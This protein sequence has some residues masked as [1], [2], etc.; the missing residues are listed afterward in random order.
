MAQVLYLDCFSG[1]AGDMLLA[2]FLDAGL[3]AAALEEA[4]G[5]LGVDHELR[6]ARVL[7]AGLSATHFSVVERST[8]PQRRAHQHEHQHA[9]SHQHE[10]Q[11]VHPDVHATLAEI[12]AAIRRSS[13]APAARDRA[14]ALFHRIAEAE[15]A[16][17]DV[18]IDRI[19]LHEVGAVDS[20]IDIVGAV[21]AFDWFGVDDVVAS[22]LNVGS[23]TIRIAHGVFPVPAPATLRLLKNVPIYSTGV[24]AELVTP[25][26]ALLVSSYAK[27]FG[28]MPSM[29]PDRV[30]YGAGT[31]DLGTAPNV[32]R[33]VIGERTARRAETAPASADVIKIECEIDDMSPQLFG[34]VVDRLL[35][36]GALDAFLAPIQ[37]KKGRPGTLLTVLSPPDRQAALVDVLFRET[38]TIGVRFTPVSRET[39]DR[40]WVEVEITGGRVRI[41]VAGRH[42]ETLNAAPEF[43]DC[44]RVAEATGRPLKLVQAEALR[45]WADRGATR[46]R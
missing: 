39:L 27:T 16:I 12:T 34:P 14:I 43:E 23:G 1:V 41:K 18:P 38:T 11:H 8:D 20:I 6:I 29:T 44:L 10:H 42:G 32:L 5:S 21:F 40:E 2:A 24:E 25:T 37:M 19:H 30:G 3:P 36:V 26:G 4:L 15:A 28:P 31:L 33:V 9:P 13:L 7:R 46:F 45:A 17:H 35:A 22:P